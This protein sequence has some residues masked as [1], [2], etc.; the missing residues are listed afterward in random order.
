MWYRHTTFGRF[1]SP[2][3]TAYDL[4]ITTV[5]R[6]NDTITPFDDYNSTNSSYIDATSI[7][8]NSSVS[9]IKPIKDATFILDETQ[10]VYTVIDSPRAILNVSS[11]FA[12]DM[13]A[14]MIETS[15]DGTGSFRFSDQTT[16]AVFV[17][18]VQ[19]EITEST[20]EDRLCT[21]K[22]RCRNMIVKIPKLYARL[23]SYDMKI[24]VDPMGY[25]ALDASLAV[26]LMPTLLIP[27][28]WLTVVT[29]RRRRAILLWQFDENP[30]PAIKC[31]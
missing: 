25:A 9:P 4:N 6:P 22:D 21:G 27:T 28:L 26:Q 5:H 13:V 8:A 1:Y 15:Y 2:R 10:F 24:R 11:G 18:G 31:V 16:F 23:A 20:I 3:L 17:G 19:T 14:V 30:F 29:V 7:N 12:D